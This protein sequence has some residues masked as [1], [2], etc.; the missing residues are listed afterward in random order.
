MK[1]QGL[2]YYNVFINYDLWMTLTYITARSTQV[3]NAFEW[4]KPL[5]CLLKLKSCRKW[6]VGLNINDSEKNWTPRA[7]APTAGHYTCILPYYSKIFCETTWPIKAKFY[8]KH[9]YNGGINV[10]INNQGHMTKMATMPI[11]GKNP[12][13]SSSLEPVDRFRRNLM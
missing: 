6:A 8:V 7:F 2:K 11:Y 13:K 9:L 4:G 3:A 10:Y 5:K 1:H 12:S